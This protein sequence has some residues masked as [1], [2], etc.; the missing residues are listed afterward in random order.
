MAGFVN[1]DNQAPSSRL[2]IPL[3]W[4][5]NHEATLMSGSVKSYEVKADGSAVYDNKKSGY[6]VTADRLL[7][8][9][10]WEKTTFEGANKIHHQEMTLVVLRIDLASHD[11]RRKFG[12]ATISLVFEGGDEKPFDSKNEPQV[13]AWAP[14][15]STERYNFSKA[16]HNKS[17]KIEAGGQAGYSGVNISGSRSSEHE[18]SWDRAAFDQASSNPEISQHTGRR[19]GIT[20][21]LEQNELQ[22]AG[23]PQTFYVAVLISRQT[24]EPYVVKFQVE[25]RIGTVEDFKNKTKKFFGSNPGKTKPYLVTP[26]E[27]TICNYEGMDIMKCIDRDNLGRLQNR[28]KSSSLELKWELS[29]QLE[30]QSSA[31][32]KQAEGSLG[33]NEEIRDSSAEEAMPASLKTPGSTYAEV[34]LPSLSGSTAADLATQ[35][36]LPPLVI[37]WQSAPSAPLSIWLG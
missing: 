19:N 11:P 10:G 2:E 7:W 37:G 4:N 5:Q 22:N 23:I 30:I 34:P 12:S 15:H 14:F 35:L 36:S 24:R 3:Y 32:A 13:Q 16:S 20:W 25:A 29:H 1:L 8:V 6:S 9:D 17:S 21:I 18:I 28:E 27:Q 26:W 31:T 33:N